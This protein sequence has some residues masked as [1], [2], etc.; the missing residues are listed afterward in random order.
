MAAWPIAARAQQ[1]AMPVIGFLNAASAQRYT[2][3]LA[4]FLK[5]LEEGGSPMAAT[6]PS[7]IVGPRATMIACRRWR[8][9][10][11]AGR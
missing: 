11:F 7:N 3:P 8:P 1:K 5:G 2:R 10:W 9:I 6:W 4:A